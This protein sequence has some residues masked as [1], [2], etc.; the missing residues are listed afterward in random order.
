MSISYVKEFSSRL[1]KNLE[2]IDEIVARDFLLKNGYACSSFM[3]PEYYVPR[4]FDT[5]KLDRIDWSLKCPL[6]KI[7]KTLDILT[8]KSSLS[9]RSFNFLNPYIFLHIVDELTQKESW[10]KVKK[11]LTHENLVC[12]YSTPAFKLKEK[13]S[14][15]ER[16][17]SSW[18][19]MAEKDLIKDCPEYNYLTVTDIK[20]FYPTL[21]THSIAWAIHGK[22]ESKKDRWNYNLLGNKLD[23]LFQNSRDG[24]T[25][26]IPVGSMVSDIIAE[27]LLV[28]I[29]NKLS[30]KIKG[31]KLLDE[32]IISRYRD[33]YR[34]LSKD[35]ENG[36]EVLRYL[37]KILNTEYDLYLNSDKTNTY[38]D[39]IESSF[40]PWSLKINNSQSLRKI[41]LGD[42]SDCFSADNL[43]NCLIET[44]RI[45]KEFINGRASVAI[46]TKLSEGLALESQKIKLNSSDIPEIISILRKITLLRE[47]VTPQTF[48]LLDTLLTRV[49][50]KEEK[51]AI[52]N[53]IKAAVSGKSDCDYQLIWFY[54]LCLSHSQKMCDILL[55]ENNNPLLKVIDRE[56]YKDDYEIFDEVDFSEN[57][58]NQLTKF[59][60]I[61]RGIL[62]KSNG[63]SIEPQSIK[64]FRY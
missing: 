61:D 2:E 13:E 50:A 11:I 47:E 60:F 25:N 62:S 30:E 26:G 32:V 38:N 46:L 57:D 48:S 33:D 44:Y 1:K 56:A 22:I 16:A 18:L 40:R 29:D 64:L 45:Q 35:A 24:Q 42:L 27:I 54:R 34:I 6:V 20:N 41:R 51:D 39:I 7:T 15:R 8:P 52:L 28:D 3:M 9:W 23:K 37:N 10:E 55:S 53:N 36:K 63:H 21:Y 49:E 19:Q 59:S 12:S 31:S 17:I 58:K 14:E 4:G 5:I 43:K